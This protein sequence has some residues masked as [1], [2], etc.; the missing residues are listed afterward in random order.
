MREEEIISKLSVITIGD[1]GAFGIAKD[2]P[3][4]ETKTE[5]FH[6]RGVIESLYIEPLRR[7]YPARYEV[8]INIIRRDCDASLPRGIDKLLKS[9]KW[10]KA[11]I[12]QPKEFT[13]N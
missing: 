13:F 2:L 10:Q 6:T 4:G 12:E 7:S 9:L 1:N 5:V 3:E 8:C 11:D